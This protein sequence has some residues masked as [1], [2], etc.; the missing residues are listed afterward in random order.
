[1]RAAAA[2]PLTARL[3]DD[4]TSLRSQ[5]ANLDEALSARLADP[6]TEDQPLHLEEV[7]VC[8]DACLALIDSLGFASIVEPEQEQSHRA[9]DRSVND[10]ANKVDQI[11][12]RV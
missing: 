5:V 9:I 7:T 11:V 3:L 6:V 12:E 1:M 2:T 4:L 10:I 8:L